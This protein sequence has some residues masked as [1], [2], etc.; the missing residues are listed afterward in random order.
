VLLRR[1]C[2]CGVEA[3]STAAPGSGGVERRGV[4]WS[5][6]GDGGW[7][8]GVGKLRRKKGRRRGVKRYMTSGPCKI[9]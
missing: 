1:G 4:A 7:R 5:G 3:W 6:G 9:L 2:G 8:R